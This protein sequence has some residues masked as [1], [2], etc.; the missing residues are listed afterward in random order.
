[1]T[2]PRPAPRADADE[3]AWWGFVA[4]REL[5]LQRCTDCGAWRYPPGPA[6]P[7]CGAAQSTWVPLSGRG[8][9]LAWTIFRRTYF[10]GLPAPYTVISVATDEG[11]LLVGNLVPHSDT[12]PPIGAPVQAVF[13]DA[14]FEDGTGGRICQWRL[15]GSDTNP[16]SEGE[17]E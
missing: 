12:P 1:M 3:Q 4:D 13:A 5:R 17:Q 11:P 10:P 7:D 8:R 2:G 9:V 6:C 15:A 16:S 14:R